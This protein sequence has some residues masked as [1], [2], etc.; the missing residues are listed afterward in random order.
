M[1][2]FALLVAQFAGIKLYRITSSS[3]SPTIAEG[4]IILTQRVAAEQLEVGDI[5]TVQR[6]PESRRVTHRVTDITSKSDHQPRQLT[7]QG[8]ANATPD[9]SFYSVEAAQRYL[10]T[11]TK[12]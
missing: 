4:A 6:A 10:F 8:D 5:V 2:L 9:P 12:E 3:M 7:L 11:L 1:L